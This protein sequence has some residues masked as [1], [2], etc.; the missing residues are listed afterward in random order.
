MDVTLIE[1]NKLD[2]VS[3]AISLLRRHE[4]KPFLDR[5]VTGDEKWIL[6]NNIR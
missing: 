5:I 4:K 6:Y 2:R 3:A 1:K